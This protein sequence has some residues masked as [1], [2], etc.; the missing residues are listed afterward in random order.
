MIQH[1]VSPVMDQKEFLTH[2]PC[3]VPYLMCSVTCFLHHD[4]VC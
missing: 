3:G 2:F 1:N 4:S